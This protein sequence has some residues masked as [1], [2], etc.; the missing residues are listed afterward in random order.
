MGFTAGKVSP[1]VLYTA[2]TS[3]KDGFPTVHELAFSA[4]FDDSGNSVAL[5][6]SATVAFELGQ[7]GADGGAKKGVYL[8]LGIEPAI[9]MKDSKVSLS[10]PVT[11]GM[12]LKDYYENP[13]TGTDSKFG[14]L[15]VGLN[16]SVPVNDQ[17]DIHGSVQVY[18]LGDTLKLFNNDKA[19]EAIG[20][21]GL[22]L[23]F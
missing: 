18:A 10:I 13:A 16:G 8:Q 15:M 23:S 12:S 2:Y 5:A 1:T 14:Y 6:P 17:V 11:L 9:P 19:S 20:S 21:I 3:P 22:G 7:N 4:D